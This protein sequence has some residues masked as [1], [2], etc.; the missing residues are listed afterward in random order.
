[1]NDT[2][3]RNVASLLLYADSGVAANDRVEYTPP[4]RHGH[5]GV[6]RPRSGVMS[7]TLNKTNAYH[8]F[9]AENNSIAKSKRP[10]SAQNRTIRGPWQRSADAL[11]AAVSRMAYLDNVNKENI[12]GFDQD[13]GT[14]KRI[15]KANNHVRNLAKP[16]AKRLK[17]EDE[18][19]R[20]QWEK[21]GFKS[22]QGALKQTQKRPKSAVQLKKE[23]IR[24]ARLSAMS[25]PRRRR[26]KYIAGRMSE[27]TIKPQTRAL[28]EAEELMHRLSP[29]Q[30]HQ[31]R[32]R[33]RVYVSP[34]ARKR[35][36]SAPPSSERRRKPSQRR[37]GRNSSFDLADKHIKK[38]IKRREKKVRNFR[39][40]L[41]A[42][43]DA[44]RG[45]D[46]KMPDPMVTMDTFENFVGDVRIAT[47]EAIAAI[48]SWRKQLLEGQ[49]SGKNLNHHI[50]LVGGADDLKK[51]KP[52]SYFW[53]EENYLTRIP[54]SLDFMGTMKL[55]AVVKGIAPK[56]GLSRNPFLLC[57]DSV[58]GDRAPFFTAE[59]VILEEEKK[60]FDGFHRGHF[61]SF[62][63]DKTPHHHTNEGDDAQNKSNFH[64]DDHR[65]EDTEGEEDDTHTELMMGDQSDID[66]DQGNSTHEISLTSSR[67]VLS[68]PTDAITL[69]DHTPQSKRHPVTTTTTPAN[70][71]IQ[72]LS[73]T[74]EE[75]KGRLEEVQR[76]RWAYHQDGRHNVDLARSRPIPSPG[77]SVS[78][79]FSLCNM[80]MSHI[81]C[82]GKNEVKKEVL[83]RSPP[84]PYHNPYAYPRSEHRPRGHSPP[85]R[86]PTREP[87]QFQ[88]SRGREAPPGPPRG[89]PPQRALDDFVK[90]RQHVVF[91]M[92]RSSAATRIQT[93]WRALRARQ[94]LA[95]L[96]GRHA[97][98]MK[99]LEEAYEHAMARQKIRTFILR[100]ARRRALERKHF[101]ATIIQSCARG[102]LKRIQVHVKSPAALV[103][104]TSWRRRIAHKIFLQRKVAANAKRIQLGWRCYCARKEV[105]LRQRKFRHMTSC[106]KIQSAWRIHVAKRSAHARRREAWGRFCTSLGASAAA[107][108][109]MRR[110]MFLCAAREDELELAAK[111]A[112]AVSPENLYRPSIAQRI[113]IGKSFVAACRDG[114]EVLVRESLA[115]GADPGQSNER[116]ETPLHFSCENGHTAITSMLLEMNA[117][118]HAADTIGRMPLHVA[119]ENGRQSCMKLLLEHGAKVNSRAHGET[120]SLHI[121]ASLDHDECASTLV[122]FDADLQAKDASGLG[123]LHY[124]AQNNATSVLRLL[125]DHDVDVDSVDA[126][127]NTALHLAVGNGHVDLVKM[128]LGYAAQT[129]LKNA[130]GDTP[131]AIAVRN[132]CNEISTLLTEYGATPRIPEPVEDWAIYTDEETGAQYWY[133][134]SRQEST[135]VVPDDEEEAKES[136]SESGKTLS[137]P[138]QEASAATTLYTPG[139]EL[140]FKKRLA[141]WVGYSPSPPPKMNMMKKN[142]MKK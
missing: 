102:L 37:S 72:R 126:Q 64:P 40:F 3:N 88:R 5:S 97:Y 105:A 127:Q 18:K 59:R 86:E 60:C 41:N 85:H 48:E 52:V 43:S 78:K 114:N 12:G 76:D 110:H 66:E 74:V 30:H 125:A 115:E 28:R 80:A 121:C 13:D 57:I 62:V 111:M 137:P 27:D 130:S 17:Y 61:V 133:S 49:K 92:R 51:G 22:V 16:R 141:K 32:A 23:K 138:P 65:N 107:Q 106:T 45:R 119:A 95:H 68:A 136:D 21:L 36:T 34:K 11:N 122:L 69:L 50:S 9:H 84:P 71:K 116:G 118:V 15:P 8:M 96:K 108:E 47:L 120:T 33:G 70:V 6:V 26:E 128:L 90:R 117:G 20:Q 7:S 81:Q 113:S 112:K 135:W 75:L 89:P 31:Q 79:V 55:S 98:H 56:M 19:K 100:V 123:A 73:A 134:H 103:I 29:M 94:Q 63:S 35:P 139:P 58:W 124:A 131:A 14:K 24:M 4:S 46:V 39:T 82:I 129:S 77:M 44:R 109:N 99:I 42:L 104:Q 38:C 1:M 25:K 87:S 2:A 83:A 10:K 53:Q 140:S 142:K 67:S 54:E 132:Q 93:N 91:V 101:A